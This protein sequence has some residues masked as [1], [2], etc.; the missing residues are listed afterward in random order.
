MWLEYLNKIGQKEK[1]VRFVQLEICYK[2]CFKIRKIARKILH[3]I[4]FLLAAAILLHIIYDVKSHVRWPVF[5][6][7][8]Q[9]SILTVTTSQLFERHKMKWKLATEKCVDNY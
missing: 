7:K 3:F 5:L 2:A 4:R 1:I 6:Q 8:L 9:S